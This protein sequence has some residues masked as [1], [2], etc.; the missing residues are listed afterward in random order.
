MGEVMIV[1]GHD[2]EGRVRSDCMGY[3][4]FVSALANPESGIS[5]WF[6]PLS[7]S[8]EALADNPKS[9]TRVLELQHALIDLIDLIDES[10][11][12]FPRY[13]DQA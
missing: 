9:G 12:R 10:C 13:R 5:E 6:N 2:A 8:L 1:T 11:V 4:A 7:L 3:A